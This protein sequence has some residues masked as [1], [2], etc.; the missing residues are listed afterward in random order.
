MNLPHKKKISMKLSFIKPNLKKKLQ[1]T[2]LM[3][4]IEEMI[5]K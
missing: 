4:S 3:E 1:I 2:Q 5:T